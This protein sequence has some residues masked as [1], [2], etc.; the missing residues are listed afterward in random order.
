MGQIPSRR[1]STWYLPGGSSE[2]EKNPSEFVARIWCC[3]DLR[4]GDDDVSARNHRST[5][6]R[7]G[8]RDR[9]ALRARLA[10]PTRQATQKDHSC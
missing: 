8:A 7:H 5:R 3:P 6:V 2:A 1:T 9:A 10:G 4:V